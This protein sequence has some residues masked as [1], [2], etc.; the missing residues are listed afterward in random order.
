[1]RHYV[2]IAIGAF[3]GA[4]LRVFF[5]SLIPPSSLG[6]FPIATVLINIIGAFLIAF[7]TPL[8]LDY[9]SKNP[10]FKKCLTT[11]LLGS[12]TTF[13]TLC[14]DVVLF[15]QENLYLSLFLYLFLTFFFGTLAVILGNKF[16]DFIN[17]HTHKIE[18][19]GN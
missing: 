8:L 11:G 14:K 16:A 12:F 6:G 18:K 4:N 17:L 19:R 5:K 7:I 2:Y 9:F 15:I 10:A 1:M 13:S 3:I